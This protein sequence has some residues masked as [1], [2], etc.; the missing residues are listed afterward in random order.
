MIEHRLDSTVVHYAWDKSIPARLEVAS[1]DVITVD[2]RGG[3]DGYY[4]PQ[5]T[6]EDVLRRPRPKGHA[7]TGPIRVRGARPGDAIRVDLIEMRTWDW[8]YT[9]VGPGWGL[10]QD[11]LPGPFLK[12]WD[13]S[14]G[15][16]AQFAP[17]I[18]IPIEPFHGILGLA[19]AAAGE[20]PTMPP[21]RTG[22]NMD[23]KQLVV[24]SS[25]WLPVEV[26]G[27]LFSIGD[28]HAAQGDGEVCITAIETGA[29]TRL[30]LTV[31]SDMPLSAPEFV[32]PG[33]LTPAANT[34]SW[35]GTM[36]IGPDLMEA[37]KDA[38]RA[39]IRYL[40]RERGLTPNESYVLASV[41]V[42]LKL[43]EVVGAPNWVVSACLPQSIFR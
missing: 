22:G 29:T 4:T 24:G 17:G 39:M 19:P 11:E 12:I 26:D 5:S 32:T 28:A 25:V 2:S 14:N 3:G 13:L 36:G 31:V 15:R 20:H 41:A 38:V 10:L 35:Y 6:H 8:G 1:G 23:T 42:D 18:E 16:T 7:L 27:G 43:S 34:G 33:P 37:T 40:G 9:F 21:L 30:R